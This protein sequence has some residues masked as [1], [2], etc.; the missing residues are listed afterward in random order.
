MVGF[1]LKAFRK[2]YKLKQVDIAKL[3]G[4]VQGNISTIETGKKS[5]EDY[6]ARILE[7]KYGREVLEEFT[8]CE[9]LPKMSSSCLA[10]EN[11]PVYETKN[12]ESVAGDLVSIPREVFEQIA[13][14]TETVLSQQRTIENLTSKEK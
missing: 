1:D 13:R 7:K 12:K 6:Q 11:I 10:A 5:L 2:K 4:C 14:L 9:N 3:F 8:I